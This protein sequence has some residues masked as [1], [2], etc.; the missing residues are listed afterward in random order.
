MIESA[1]HSKYPVIALDAYGD[2]DLKLLAESYSLHHDF[3]SRYSPDALYKASRHLSYDAISYTSNLE[4][5]PNILRRTAG[6]R[7]TI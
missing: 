7:R 6:E 2:Q 4:N 3:N 5:H 1:V